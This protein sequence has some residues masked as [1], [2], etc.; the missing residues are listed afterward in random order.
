MHRKE[1]YKSEYLNDSFQFTKKSQHSM[2]FRNHW[3]FCFYQKCY[4]IEIIIKIGLQK[5]YFTII[6]T[7]KSFEAKHKHHL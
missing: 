4:Q 2:F 1:A 6:I 3:Q 5:I 7:N